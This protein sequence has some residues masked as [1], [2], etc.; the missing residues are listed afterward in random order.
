MS[1]ASYFTETYSFFASITSTV[2]LE[3]YSKGFEYL[4]SLKLQVCPILGTL[5]FIRIFSANHRITE[6][7]GLEETIKII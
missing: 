1:G 3:A 7:F 2:I 5:G 4:F 6:W